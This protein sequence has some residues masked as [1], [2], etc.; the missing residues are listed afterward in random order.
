MRKKRSIENYNQIIEFVSGSVAEKAPIIPIS[1]QHRMNIDVLIEN[2]ERYIPTPE[3]INNNTGI[4]HILR[5]FDI[6]K[7]GTPIKNIKG[8]R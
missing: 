6:N 4:M 3:R 8:G 2:I 5:L 7:P 1:A